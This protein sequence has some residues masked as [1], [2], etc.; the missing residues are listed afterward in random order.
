MSHVL[1]GELILSSSRPSSPTLES[2]LPRFF[3]ADTTIQHPH[4]IARYR[5]SV[6][7]LSDMLG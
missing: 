3:A 7:F 1:Q 5:R 4:T 2:L 6:K